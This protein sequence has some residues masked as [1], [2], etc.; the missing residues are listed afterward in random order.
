MSSD[1][2]D[3]VSFLDILDALHEEH[4]DGKEGTVSIICKA[5]HLRI[6]QARTVQNIMTEIVRCMMLGIEYDGTKEKTAEGEDK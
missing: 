6:T 3:P 5:M 4:W 2:F 1:I